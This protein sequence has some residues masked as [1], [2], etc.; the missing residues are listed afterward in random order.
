MLKAAIWYSEVLGFSIIPVRSTKKPFVK[1]TEYQT[2]KPDR[3]QIEEW[4]SKWPEANIGIV[5]GAISGIDVVDCDSLAGKN[6]L[7]EFLN[8]TFMTPVSKTPNGWH[9]YFKHAEG[10]SNGVRVI[11]DCDLRTTGG[12]IIA[13]PSKNGNGVY[14]WCPGLKIKETPFSRSEERRVGKECRSR[15][16][17]YH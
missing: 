10:L 6:A 11:T 12:Y 17:P 16:S 1:W 14:E 4:W 13:P 15:W 3:N 8:D 5:T 2:E 9:Y 7:N